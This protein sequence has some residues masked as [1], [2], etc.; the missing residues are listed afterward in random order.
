MCGIHKRLCTQSKTGESSTVKKHVGISG[1][2]Q[3]KPP[4]FGLGRRLVR[5]EGIEPPWP[6][7]KTG[8]LSVVL[9]A[10]GGGSRDGQDDRTNRVNEQTLQHDPVRPFV[11]SV[12]S[13]CPS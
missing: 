1:T 4:P 6:V 5:L 11:L 13:S 9:Q 2:R 3:P 8:V 10:L 12:L 7:P